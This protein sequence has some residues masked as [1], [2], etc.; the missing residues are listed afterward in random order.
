MWSRAKEASKTRG[1]DTNKNPDRR[2]EDTNRKVVDKEAAAISKKAVG[3]EMITHKKDVVDREAAEATEAEEKEV[4]P[5][6]AEADEATEMI[7]RKKVTTSTKLTHLSTLLKARTLR[8]P[9]KQA[10][11]PNSHRQENETSMKSMNMKR[12]TPL[13]NTY[14][15][16]EAGEVEARTD[17]PSTIK[18]T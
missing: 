13:R 18:S 6:G 8:T 17:Q 5:V 16:E 3:R 1:E 4:A 7:T 14:M 9:M 10:K 12:E 15:V 11:N 2:E